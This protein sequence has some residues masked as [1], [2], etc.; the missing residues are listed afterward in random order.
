VAL[1]GTAVR[2]KVELSHV[3]RGVF[4]SLDVKMARHP[5]ENERMLLAR[6]FSFCLFHE[7][8][9]ALAKG[10]L[11]SPDEP[12]LSVHTLDGRL[13]T[14]ID[15]GTPS[16]ERLHKASKAAPRVIVVTQHDPALLQRE[17]AG[18]HV[19]KL[20]RIEAFALAPAFL[21]DVAQHLSDRGGEL[22]LTV[23]EGQLY[24]TL[25]GVTVEGALVRVPLSD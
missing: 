11:S 24:V 5:S 22:S 10:G 19:H 2:F 12:A 8:G 25:G 21:D 14:W 7:E 13:T 3:D 20:E 18:K 15:V 16:A 4:A 9:L 1:Q 6:L 23:T 17:V